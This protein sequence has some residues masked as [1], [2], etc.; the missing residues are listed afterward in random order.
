MTKKEDITALLKVSW[1]V[2][3]LA[4]S[5]TAAPWLFPVKKCRSYNLISQFIFNL[6]LHISAPRINSLHG[7][8]LSLFWFALMAKKRITTMPI[9]TAS[10]VIVSLLSSSNSQGITLSK[11]IGDALRGVTKTFNI[12]CNNRCKDI[13]VT[14]KVDSGDP[15]LYASEE[16]PPKIGMTWHMRAFFDCWVSLSS[17]LPRHMNEMKSMILTTN[18]SHFRIQWQGDF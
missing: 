17:L 16:Q 9:L 5:Y 15:D 13:T 11:D 12:T 3:K 8:S 2:P 4:G 7:L 6:S 10:L 14:I 1:S 18:S